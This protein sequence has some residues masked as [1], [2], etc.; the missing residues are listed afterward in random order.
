MLLL[1]PFIVDYPEYLAEMFLFMHGLCLSLGN[2]GVVMV[3][4]CLLM[5]MQFLLFIAVE[6]ANLG[7]IFHCL[8]H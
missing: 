4:Q 5:I 7:P 3:L 8:K 6:L 2:M 1:L